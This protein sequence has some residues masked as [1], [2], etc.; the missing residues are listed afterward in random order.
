MKIH[1]V[2]HALLSEA[3]GTGYSVPSLCDTLAQRGH[4]VTIHSL[5][6]EMPRPST[7]RVQE[8]AH[9]RSLDLLGVSSAMR[10]G[11]ERAARE[12]DILHSHSLWTLPTIYPAWAVRGTR[13]KLVASPRGTLAPV[14]L[15][16]SKRK[17]QL[18]WTLLQKR[19]LNSAHLL[20]ATADSERDEFRALGLTNP[21]AVIPNGIHLPELRPERDPARR[22]LL[23]ISRI[24]PKKGIPDLLRAWQRLQS[25]FPAWELVV[26]GPDE[27]GHLVEM[28]QLA[29]SL[30]LERVSFP[31]AVLGPDKSKLYFGSELFV[32][33]THNENFG[34]VV[35][36]AQAH[37][38]PAIVTRGAPWAGLETQGSGWWTDIG[39]DALERALREA[40]SMSTEALANMGARGRAWMERDFSWAMVTEKTLTTYEWLR[41]GGTP[42]HWVT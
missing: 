15:N 36:E 34:N 21:V 27:R 30:A 7:F 41:S 25:R 9:W 17:K 28:K 37:G 29:Q 4:E 23:F 12:G 18:V 33:P 22:K 6:Y 5:R 2:V 3:A 39:T 16:H 19:A 13:C 35:T 10:L 32:L 14:T 26:A 40:M 1:H 31:G 11:L 8:Y 24:H 42:P 38:L 20:H